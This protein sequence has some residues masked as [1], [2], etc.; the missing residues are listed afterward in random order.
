MKIALH[1]FSAKI[2]CCLSRP[3][4]PVSHDPESQRF[5]VPRPR[6]LAKG[7]VHEQHGDQKSATG[8]DEEGYCLSRKCH[9]ISPRQG[10]L[11][12]PS[13]LLVPHDYGKS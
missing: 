1:K 4:V 7:G 5:R 3:R 2:R 11:E 9:R 12:T 8:R 6:V 10:D 13:R